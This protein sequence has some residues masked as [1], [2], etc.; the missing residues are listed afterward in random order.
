[1]KKRKITAILLAAAVMTS[2]MMG[3]CK[4]GSDSEAGQISTE[5]NT[6]TILDTEA[7]QN[8]ISGEKVL[9]VASNAMY[10]NASLDV[11]DNSTYNYFNISTM[12]IGECLFRLDDTLT[13]QPWLAKEAVQED[14]VTWKITLRDDVY[15]HNG[16]KMGAESV[17]RCLERTLEDF[18]LAAES[19]SVDTIEVTDAYELKLVTNDVTPG[20]MSILSDTM[21]MIYDFEDGCDF[22]VESSYTGPFVLE[23]REQDVSKT[24]VR[25]ED[26]W[27]GAS[28]IS[29]IVYKVTEN[30]A[31]ALEVGD[32]DL[33]QNVSISDLSY[34]ESMDGF[35]VTSA[36][37]PRGEQI[38]FNESHEGVND[39]TVR[40][41]IAMCFDRETIAKTIYGGMAVA[42]YG[43]FPDFLSFGGTDRLDLT[44]DS[45]NPE[46]AAKL[47]ADAGYADTDG[48][49]ILD[50][51]G[52]KLSFKVVCYQDASLLAVAD[53][54]T[55]AL[56]NI[57]IE[58]TTEATYD[59]RSYEDT[60][61]FDIIMI[62]YGMAMIGNPYYWMNTMVASS[63]NA[64]TGHYNNTEVDSLIAKMNTTADTEQRDALCF[65]IQQH[66]LDDC[67]WVVFAHKSIYYVYA[68]KVMNFTASPCQYYTIDNQIDI[69]E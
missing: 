48:D 62:T 42:S 23:S 26:Y 53:L 39:L 6:E 45:Y 12:G 2:V 58:L 65:E 69:A 30:P 11:C 8:D 13:P 60:D 33:A 66:M 10:I 34:F 67:H 37:V 55:S 61:D 50:K 46:G 7:D 15:Y 20:L 47:L 14:S 31:A 16:N 36:L 28:N 56:K 35:N 21:F 63:A 3:G 41:A 22:A 5:N 52:V 59:T 25:F 27:G 18:D 49:G 43:I 17:K 29:K 38:W 68:D 40:R 57:G 9:N 1:M 32:V 24:L 51:D 4:S 19:L 44:V 54:L 64:N